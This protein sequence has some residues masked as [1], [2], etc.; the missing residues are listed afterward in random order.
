MNT[1]TQAD[2]PVIAIDGPAAAGKG[3]VARLLA[4]TLQFHYLDSG[5]IYRAVA[6][7]ATAQ[8]ISP[9]DKTAIRELAEEL[10]K[11]ATADMLTQEGINHPKIG[12]AASQLASLADVRELLLPMQQ[13]M[14]RA[15][16]LVADGR[17][18]GAVVFPDAILKVFLTANIDI[19][20]ERRQKQL[21]EMQINATI[22][23][24]LAD[25]QQRDQRD[26]ARS[27]SPLVALPDSITVDS[28][29]MS[30]VH[31]VNNLAEQFADRQARR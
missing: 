9:N 14:R 25:L 13:R 10:A 28:S 3:A 1:T 29:C 22:K 20:A 31:I 30:V 24:V 2:S 15:P 19:R 8:N 7:A 4:E 12:E 18:M 16:G 27:V 26:S 6:L 11:T 21:A 23:T 5:K 17:D